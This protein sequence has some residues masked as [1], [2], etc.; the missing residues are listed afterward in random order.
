LLLLVNAETAGNDLGGATVRRIRTLKKFL[1]GEA[2][3]DP[4]V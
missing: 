3:A 4:N 2:N 1:D